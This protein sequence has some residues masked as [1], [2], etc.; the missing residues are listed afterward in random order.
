M[1]NYDVDTRWNYALRIIDDAFESR[2]PLNDSCDDIDAL[3]DLK[4]MPGE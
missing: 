1:V 4:L 3:K 2:V